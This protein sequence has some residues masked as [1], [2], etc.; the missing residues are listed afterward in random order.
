MM[1]I[2]IAINLLSSDFKYSYARELLW[3]THNIML[4][5]FYSSV[6]LLLKYIFIP[7]II[8]L[9]EYYNILL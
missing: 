4:Y 1:K 6:Y 7:V 9:V 8:L 2:I 5:S 3:Y